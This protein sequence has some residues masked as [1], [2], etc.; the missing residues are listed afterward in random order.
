MDCG[1]AESTRAGEHVTGDRHVVSRHSGGVL[2]AVIDGLGHGTEAARAAE[3]AVALLTRCP[4]SDVVTLIAA[5]HQELRGSRGVV[6]TVVSLAPAVKTMSFIGVGNV[7]GMI[8]PA[9]ARPREQER[10]FVPLRGGVV[11]HIVPPIRAS[12]RRLDAGDTLILATDGVGIEF[13]TED[14]L[15]G[16]PQAVAER[17]LERYAARTD[18]AL[19]L[20]ARYLGG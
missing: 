9:A 2:L 4:S 15:S 17:I 20:V 5:C 10:D 7:Q 12:V 11:G 16:P 1:V 8:I 3:T 14:R 6:M 19:V 18:D 13:M